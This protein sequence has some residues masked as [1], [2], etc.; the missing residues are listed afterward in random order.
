MMTFPTDY[1]SVQEAAVALGVHRS[2]VQ[3]LLRKNRIPG[4][5]QLR[6]MWFIP[7][8]FNILLPEENKRRKGK[9]Y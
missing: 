2:R 9:W 1:L 8:D 3:A 6:G 4:A 7:R 5:I